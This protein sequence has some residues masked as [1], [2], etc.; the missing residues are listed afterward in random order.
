MTENILIAIVSATSALLGVLVASAVA[1][2]QPWYNRK[3]TREVLLREKYE[4]LGLHFLDSMKLPGEL[5]T[6]TSHEETL[7]V[8]HQSSGNKAH[9]LALVYFPILQQAT[10]RHIE[11]YSN[12]CLATLS[13]YDPTDSRRVG[14]QVFNQPQYV[15][16][17]DQ[18]I[19]A[20]DALQEEIQRN[21]HIYARA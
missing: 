13:L 8:T 2:V 18:H 10:G 11:S 19:A 7:A 1:M 16:A 6:C 9:L 17:R 12:L 21:A 5:L 20:R 4:E 14:E 3:Y 15:A